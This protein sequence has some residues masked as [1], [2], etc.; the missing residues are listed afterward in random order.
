MERTVKEKKTAATHA[1][2]KSSPTPIC[3]SLHVASVRRRPEETD[4]RNLGEIDQRRKS[5]NL[6]L[7]EAAKICQGTLA[8]IRARNRR[9]IG[10]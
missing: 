2:L 9:W 4:G 3:V 8:T 10:P 1:P 6:K 5:S 7:K